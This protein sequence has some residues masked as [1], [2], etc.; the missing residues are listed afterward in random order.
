MIITIGNIFESKAQ[1]LVNT[2]NCV[3]VMGKGIA[4]EFKKRYPLMFKD[5]SERCASHSITAGQPYYYSDLTGASVINFPTK[6]H[7]RSPSQLSYIIDGLD[8]FVNNYEKLKIKSVA[9]PPL[10]CGNGGLSWDTVGPIMYQKLNNL[11]IDIEIYAPFGTPPSKLQTTFLSRNA[12]SNKNVSGIKPGKINPNWYLMLYV[13]NEL[14]NKRYSLNVGRTIFQKICYVLTRTG[15]NT[16]FSFTKGC[17]GPYSPQI[18]EAITILSNANLM[19]ETS[20]GQMMKMTVTDEFVFDK[21]SFSTQD[22]NAADKTIDLFSRVKNT[23][24]AE[25]IATVMYSYD[26][27][28]AKNTTVYDKD[29]YKFVMDWK[30]HWEPDKKE[31]VCD[32]ILNLMVLGWINVGY[33]NEIEYNYD[34]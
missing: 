15:V 17:Y 10:G 31:A 32:A 26:V 1:V 2:V 16:G 11:P 24:H 28:A 20:I 22:I 12:C 33:S 3:G 18:R 9:F 29:V 30:K 4:A 25:M 23:D 8:W 14:E 5:Y 6:D 34:I 27:L 19:H 13:V 7:W 21:C